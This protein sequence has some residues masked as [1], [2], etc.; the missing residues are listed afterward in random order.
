MKSLIKK[1]G[2]KW[3]VVILIV[4]VFLSATVFDSIYKNAYSLE[5]SLSYV[6]KNGDPFEGQISN[7][8]KTL[9][10][11]KLLRNGKPIEGHL[12]WMENPSMTDKYGQT[13]SGG[14]LKQNQCKTDENGEAVFEYFPYKVNALF[15]PAGEVNFDVRDMDA[16][17]FIEMRVGM[18]FT[19]DVGD[20]TNGNGK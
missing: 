6:D 10:K 14:N 17:V 4:L 16:S 7:A 12:L 13:V 5:Y 19:I 11:V 9:I 3:F 18:T 2:V 8:Y 20:K 1:I 15:K